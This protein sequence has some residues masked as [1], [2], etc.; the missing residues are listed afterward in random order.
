MRYHPE[1]NFTIT[2]LPTTTKPDIQAFASTIPAD[3]ALHKQLC[4]N[5]DT[6][7]HLLFLSSPNDRTHRRGKECRSRLIDICLLFGA[8][9]HPPSTFLLRNHPTYP[10]L[11]TLNDTYR[12]WSINIT[13]HFPAPGF[14][15]SFNSRGE[16]ACNAIVHH[17]W[18]WC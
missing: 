16:L 4:D 3:I 5:Y 6:R 14:L 11:K 10:P 15:C 8:S 12:S 18:R 2:R 9:S 1:Y 7:H 17:S 13:G